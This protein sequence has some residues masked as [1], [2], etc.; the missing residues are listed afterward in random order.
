MLGELLLIY[1]AILWTTPTIP[2]LSSR[3]AVTPG[4]AMASAPVQEGL[5]ESAAAVDKV[6]PTS[7]VD[8]KSHEG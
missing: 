8:A 6:A 2:P 3:P 1:A 5:V 4:H 7:S